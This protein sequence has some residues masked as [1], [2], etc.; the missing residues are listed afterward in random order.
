LRLTRLFVRDLRNLREVS[1]DVSARFVV[2]HGENGHGKT[3]AL[4]AVWLLASLRGLRSPKH[5]E[6]IRHGAAEAEVRGLV[7]S[8]GVGRE[9]GVSLGPSGRRASLDGKVVHQLG[10][11]FAGIRAIAFTPTDAAIILEDPAQRRQWLDRAAFTASP[12]HLDV[13]ADYRRCLAQKAALLREGRPD[14]AVLDVIDAQLARLGAQLVSRRLGLL[15]ALSPHVSALH[16]E[17][18]GGGSGALDLSLL[19]CAPGK[20]PGEREVAL[21]ERFRGARRLELERRSPQVGPHRDELRV[22]LDTRAARAYGSRGQVRSIVLALKLAELVAARERGETPL[23]LL[24]DLSSELDRRRTERLVRVLLSLE[25]QVW[26]STTDPDHI[27]GLPPED[28]LRVA[29]REGSLRVA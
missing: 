14:L 11:Y 17:I 9:H 16:A 3:N 13:V 25:A 6:L 22:Q 26:V 12:A 18:S 10:D 4:E 23:F 21:G 8:K 15:Q 20:T 28:T 27:A 7:W 5:A 19:T 2:L 29:V 24:D 1:L